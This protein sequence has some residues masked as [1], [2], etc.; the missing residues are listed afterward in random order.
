MLIMSIHAT[1]GFQGIPQNSGVWT[2]KW[3]ILTEFVMLNIIVPL[4]GW[5]AHWGGGGIGA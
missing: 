2:L 1:A 3:H 5:G 4:R